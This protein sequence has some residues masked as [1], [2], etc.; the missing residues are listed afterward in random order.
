MKDREERE[1]CRRLERERERKKDRIGE[2]ERERKKTGYR[3]Y[4]NNTNLL[5]ILTR[6]E[7]YIIK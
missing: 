5:H 1:K 7:N 3:E 6:D 2:K 4:I